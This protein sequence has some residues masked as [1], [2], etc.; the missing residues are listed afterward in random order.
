LSKTSATLRQADQSS[1]GT[2]QIIYENPVTWLHLVNAFLKPRLMRGFL[3]EWKRTGFSA[4]YDDDTEWLAILESSLSDSLEDTE[5]DFAEYL[6]DHTVRL[7]HGCR[8]SGLAGYMRN[9]IRPYDAESFRKLLETFLH[10]KSVAPYRRFILES[11]PELADRGDES[12]VFLALDER[13]LLA[14][15][16][17]YLIYGSEWLTSALGENGRQV[18]KRYGVPTLLYVNWPLRNAS[19]SEL[20]QFAHRI[21]REW[22]RLTCLGT[23]STCFADFTFVA[24]GG[25]DASLI[26]G[27]RHPN[28]IT[29]PLEGCRTY[30]TRKRTC[31][32]CTASIVDDG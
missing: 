22:V 24:L 20:L 31:D 25:V 5:S 29:D 26:A 16:G 13:S 11:I 12:K 27:H 1:T 8:P 15:A 9:G 14:Y 2:S 7:A 32:V 4:S 19:R 3:R 28:R 21:F 10:K 23:V 18:L 17:H 30:R 6:C